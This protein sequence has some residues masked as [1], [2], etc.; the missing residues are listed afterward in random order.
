MSFFPFSNNTHKDIHSSGGFTGIL[1]KIM[2]YKKVG[3]V[4]IGLEKLR[5]LPTL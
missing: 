5:V 4:F 2:G 3:V 1:G